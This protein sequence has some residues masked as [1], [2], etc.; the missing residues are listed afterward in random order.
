MH[1]YATR[2]IHSLYIFRFL[3]SLLGGLQ[4]PPTLNQII[5]LEIGLKCIIRELCTRGTTYMKTH[6]EGVGLMM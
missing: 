3:T 6:L 1:L 2:N 5:S 4:E